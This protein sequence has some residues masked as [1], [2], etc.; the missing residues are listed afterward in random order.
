MVVVAAGGALPVRAAA[1]RVPA[2]NI[3]RDV[4][5]GRR[6]RQVAAV[7]PQPVV[8]DADQR[9]VRRPIGDAIDGVVGCRVQTG[10][11]EWVAVKVRLPETLA[12]V[13]VAGVHLAIFARK[14]C[15]VVEHRE[16]VLASDCRADFARRR[17][18]VL[19]HCD[20]IIERAVFAI[21][22]AGVHVCIVCSRRAG[23]QG[24]RKG[25]R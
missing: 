17:N 19:R 21:L 1:V 23:V 7:N 12:D 8:G 24:R 15:A 25:K 4:A 10:R 11:A 5:A 9:R 13:L 22:R 20:G 2:A 3:E 18:V 16:D 6:A 14:C